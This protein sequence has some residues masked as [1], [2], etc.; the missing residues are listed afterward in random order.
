MSLTTRFSGHGPT[1]NLF[2]VQDTGTHSPAVKT[3]RG[4]L[5][6]QEQALADPR[7]AKRRARR[8]RKCCIV[9]E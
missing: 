1:S 3:S 2:Q 9:V 5:T 7:I 4:V 6:L 8:G